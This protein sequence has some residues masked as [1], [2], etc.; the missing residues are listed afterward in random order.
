M[1]EYFF[2]ADLDVIFIISDCRPQPGVVQRGGPPITTNMGDLD[3]RIR[4]FFFLL[5]VRE[6]TESDGRQARK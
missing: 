6:V 1:A 3:F 5:G 2:I 4:E